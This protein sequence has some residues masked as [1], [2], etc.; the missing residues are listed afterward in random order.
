MQIVLA[1]LANLATMDLFALNVYLIMDFK[2]QVVLAFL[3]QLDLLRPEELRLV[4]TLILWLM[5]T[6]LPL[7]QV[8]LIKLVLV[9]HQT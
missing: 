6:K 2:H 9:F 1:K 5:L 4:S 3:A 8:R 7:I